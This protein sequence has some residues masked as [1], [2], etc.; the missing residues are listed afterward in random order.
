MTRRRVVEK[1]VGEEKSR[2]EAMR[3]EFKKLLVKYNCEVM[4]SYSVNSA[5]QIKWAVDFRESGAN[6]KQ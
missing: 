6:A 1:K 2:A 5:D 3:D 4:L